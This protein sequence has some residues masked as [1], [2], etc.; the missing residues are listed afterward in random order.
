[1]TTACHR[2]P[3]RVQSRLTA[4]LLCTALMV[5]GGSQA[6]ALLGIDAAPSA[7]GGVQIQLRTDEPVAQPQSFMITDPARLVLD[8][9]GV[10]S[11]VAER[12]RDLKV[13]PADSV[14]VVEVGGRTRVVVNLATAQPYRTRLDGSTVVVDIGG[15]VQ[16]AQAAARSTPLATPALA[17]ATPMG[18]GIEDVDFRRAEDGRGRVVIRLAD[19]TVPITAR[20]QGTRVLVEFR[21]AELPAR[22]SRRL[23]VT[24]FGTPVTTV[25]TR[26]RGDRVRVDI[27]VSGEFDYV[28][29][30]TGNEFI[31]EVSRLT[32]ETLAA[33]RDARIYTGEPISLNF[34]NIEVRAVLQLLADFTGKNLVASD[35]VTGTVTLRLQNVPWDQALDIILSARGLAKR[36][37]GNVMWVAPAE[38][39]AARERLEL[40]TRKQL[41]ELAPLYTENLSVNFAKASDV[42]AL[43]TTE[44]NK[45][46][47][48]RGNV[49]VD[50]RTNT[51]LVRDTEAK[52]E[53]IREL[54]ALLDI[55]VRQVLI[56]SRVVNASTTFGK[57]L[58]VRFGAS[59]SRQP[60]DGTNIAL[61]GNLNGTT[62]LVNGETLAAD[63]RLNV[64]MPAGRLE[65]INFNPSSIALAIAK[66]PFGRLLELELSALQ[67][68]GEGEILSNPRVV[69]ANQREAVIE[70]GTEIPYQEAAASGATNVE[71]KEAVLSLRVTPQITPDNHVIMDIEVTNDTP[72]V[73]LSN[74]TTGEPA[75]NTQS[76]QTQ[77]LVDNG[78]TLVLGGI[79]QQ[80]SQNQVVRT[81]FFGDLPYVG[82][83]F[84][85]RSN[86]SER[87]ELLIFVTPRIL[88]EGLAEL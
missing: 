32:R 38:E 74:A 34:Q 68:S 47:T 53:E 67:A 58:G 80:D 71:F 66:L 85:N 12:N 48:E 13:G 4:A 20:A 61:S 52:L 42:A 18:R 50:E 30:Q 1:M 41:E 45:L 16:P 65:G 72:N 23:D 25:E 36:E 70:Q 27:D 26:D 78:E 75:I 54:L 6:A 56:E 9:A 46:L 44:G 2:A 19:P 29:Y 24:D 73:T 5:P 82:R 49:T 35:S 31:I 28:A 60:G 62:Q 51:L 17:A 84:Q 8:F 15:R 37:D 76:V 63:D 83:L 55:P 87:R 39:I 88:E 43:L 40:E 79:Y 7:D 81:P 10:R 59:R 21:D 22:L 33:R 11:Q 77:V 57:N 64:N 69:T 3:V 86:T 14:T